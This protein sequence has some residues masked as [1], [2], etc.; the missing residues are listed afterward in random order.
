[1]GYSPTSKDST[2]II[3]LTDKNEV[4]NSTWKQHT[5][6]LPAEA[7]YVCIHYCTPSKGYLMCLDNVFIGTGSNR[8]PREAA[9]AFNH[10]K[11]YLDEKQVGT[12]TANSYKLT[13]LSKG[14]HTAKVTAVYD[15]GESEPAIVNFGVETGISDVQSPKIALYPN[16]ASSTVSFG[17][18][19]D[20][21][22][23][24]EAGS[25]REVK[26]IKQTDSMDVSS[27][28]AGLYIV[29]I[30]SNGHIY[31]SKLVIER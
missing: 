31:V 27:L 16:P 30:N 11:V 21:A 12:T 6:T 24:Y 9:P 25:G 5:Y 28:P 26:S 22:Q 8:A 4:V 18:K 3:W 13:Q 15:E 20:K 19:V 29:R 7:Q 2:D 23:L 10:Y 17:Q 14:Q 1:M